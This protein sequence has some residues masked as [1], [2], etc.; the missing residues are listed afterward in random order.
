MVV[1]EVREIQLMLEC[2]CGIPSEDEVE[3]I[4]EIQSAKVR[5][6]LRK[7]GWGYG[8][9]INLNEYHPEPVF[10]VQREDEAGGCDA[11][12]PPDA[13]MEKLEELK[14]A[15]IFWNENSLNEAGRKMLDRVFDLLDEL[16]AV[17]LNWY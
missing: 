16:G 12:I 1:E 15:I 14:R 4:N 13:D 7:Y 6:F 3:E 10:R 9:N 5:R 11:L 17:E 2:F 8:V